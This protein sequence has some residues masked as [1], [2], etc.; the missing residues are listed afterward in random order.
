MKNVHVG[1]G[2]ALVLALLISGCSTAGSQ[3]S[4]ANEPSASQE[5]QPQNDWWP[6]DGLAS[7][8]PTPDSNSGE[9]K[10]SNDS[11]FKAEV[12]DSDQS[13]FDVYVDECKEAG[14][15]V[16]AEKNSAN[17]QA[18]NSDGY[19]LNVNLWKD[20]NKYYVTLE[21]PIELSEI[22]WPTVGPAAVVPAPESTLGKTDVNTDERYCVWI[23]NTSIK[24]YSAYVDTLISSG[25]N[26]DYSRQDKWFKAENSEGYDVHAEYLGYDIMYVLV[27]MP[28]S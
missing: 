10:T 28:E 9:V 6:T 1:V 24:D 27:D 7:M 3:V 21:S 12:L 8:L 14:F 17:F 15:T 16:D 4:G 22:T 20:D 18:W 5:A 2:V 11:N 25:F 13:A 23:G 19:E 26:V